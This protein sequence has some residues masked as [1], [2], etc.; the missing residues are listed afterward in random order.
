MARA[1]GV[2]KLMPT[3]CVPRVCSILKWLGE[4]RVLLVCSKVAGAVPS[5]FTPTFWE[6]VIAGKENNNI[7]VWEHYSQTIKALRYLYGTRRM[8]IIA[9]DFFFIFINYTYAF[10]FFLWRL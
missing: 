1:V 10:R 8:D 6:N 4:A 3:S 7:K 5:V 2:R 9:E